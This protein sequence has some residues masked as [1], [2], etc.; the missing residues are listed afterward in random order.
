MS[1]Q[2]CLPFPFYFPPHPTLPPAILMSPTLEKLNW[3]SIPSQLSEFRSSCPRL[4]GEGPRNAGAEASAAPDRAG[5]EFWE[6]LCSWSPLGEGARPLI[7]PSLVPREGPGPCT[8]VEGDGT[9]LQEASSQPSAPCLV[10][11]QTE[12]W[13]SWGPAPHLHGAHVCGK[14]WGVGG[15]GT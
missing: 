5:S 14:V 15:L 10:E 1:C 13:R 11:S 6:C 12:A 9:P 8:R 7:N 2:S 4:R 3:D